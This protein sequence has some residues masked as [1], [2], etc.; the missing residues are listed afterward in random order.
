MK[1][2]I[3]EPFRIKVIEP[4]KMTT[5]EQ[6]KKLIKDAH[7]NVFQLHSDDVIIDLLTDSGTS[8]QSAEQIAAL[9][10]GDESYAG[11][12]S[13]YRFLESVRELMPFNHIFPTHQGRAAERILARA[14]AREGARVPN[15]TFFD[16][17]RANF[18][19]QGIVA[20]DLPIAEGLQPATSHPF[21]GNMDIDKLNAYLMKYAA[22]IPLVML[23]ITN[24][25]GG[26]QP[27]SLENIRA[28]KT[29]CRKYNKPLFIDSCRFAENA[30]F[31]KR[32][33]VG[34]ANLS[35]KE[36]VQEIFSY[37]DGMTMSAKKDPFGN[38]GGWLGMND[39]DLAELCRAELI[40]SEGFTTYGGLAGRDLD[41][42]AV[43]LRESIDESYLN[44]RLRTIEYFGEALTHIGIPIIK[45]VGGH[46]LFID[47][48]ALLPH[49][50]PSA[51]PGLA[52][53][54][55]LYE[56]CGVRSCEIGSLM[57]G[58]R[59]VSGGESEAMELVRLALPRRVYTQSHIDYVIEHCEELMM[60]CSQLGGYKI[61]WQ[62]RYLRHFTGKFAKLETKAVA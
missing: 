55:A 35:I 15:N 24:N 32:R 5:V 40:I 10:R 1:K 31:I 57:F 53:V 41:A 45:P 16:T 20:D 21:K 30:M 18:E 19:E 48:K 58:H 44:Y 29:L 54:V 43:G 28:V 11:S 46:A 51:Y 4:I 9:T 60:Q 33:E 36:I 6:R 26:G 17:T 3:I 38:I 39:D 2:T 37:A 23:T 12:P 47:A 42:I 61:I 8:A 49:I 25:A 62:P 34:Y 59:D 52:L 22:H 56:I 27:V 14:I 7:Y 13:F 50:P